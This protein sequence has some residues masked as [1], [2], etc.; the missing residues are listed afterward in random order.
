M[1]STKLTCRFPMRRN[2]SKAKPKFPKAHAAPSRAARTLALAYYVEQLIE[3]GEH[4]K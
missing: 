4:V 1:T 2:P 3:A